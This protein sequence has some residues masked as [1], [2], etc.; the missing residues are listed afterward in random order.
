MT[1]GKP[2]PPGR[3]PVDGAAREDL[4]ALFVIERLH[5][6]GP[7]SI[8][9]V[10][11]DVEYDQ[12]VALKVMP[13]APQAD[14]S[15]EDAFQHAAAAAAVLD[16][17]HIVPLYS[18]GATDR[19][20][21]CSMRYI[22]GRSLADELRSGGP[23]ELSA[24]LRV[25]AEVAAALEFGHRLGVI[26]AGLKP[27]NVLVDAA[28]DARV[29]DFWVPWVL[30]QLDALTAGGDDAWPTA[31]IAPEQRFRREAGPAADQYALALLV[32]TCL[33]GA[34]PPV[35]DAMAAI[36]AGRDPEPL[37]R[38]GDIRHDIPPYVSTAIERAMSRAPDG[39]YATPLDFVAALQAPPVRPH[40]GGPM[41]LSGYEAVGSY[42]APTAG[43]R[44]IPG[45]LLSLVVLGAVAAPWLLSSGS[46]GE[47][48]RA[49]GA[50]SAAPRRA[51]S[52]GLSEPAFEPLDTI[53]AVAKPPPDQPPVMTD[54]PPR[55]MSAPS[56][57]RRRTAPPPPRA[58]DVARPLASPGRLFVNATPW[59]E[60][61]V[62]DALIGN[63]PQVSLPVL[64]GAH[65]LRVV[66]DGFEPFD[67][68]IRVAAGQELRF[69]DIVLHE[70]K[71]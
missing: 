49:S 42:P 44:W 17:P 3:D 7:A 61:Y 62:D 58:S 2:P 8:V 6:R 19:L 48:T 20:F 68:T 53:P 28:G 38:L 15:A 14:P 57:P 54:A 4:S 18:A 37:P 31:Y 1:S 33:N 22:E 64:A 29:T 36:A 26:H 5:R 70:L 32:Y 60:V 9:Y 27:G 56:P 55:R 66:R 35:E 69:T 71:P 45:A 21:W 52:L 67:L 43:W 12:P 25:A 51:D 46:T 16:H 30:T 10:A 47:R 23:M 40:A 11:R 59:G 34:P 50:A 65:R 24:G 63:T 41:R 13:R 39:R